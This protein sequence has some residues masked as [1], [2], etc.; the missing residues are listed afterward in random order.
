[1]PSLS[2]HENRFVSSIQC[3]AGRD[4][5]IQFELS[6]VSSSDISVLPLPFAPKDNNSDLDPSAI[7]GASQKAVEQIHRKYQTL[8]HLKAIW[9]S[10]SDPPHYDIYSR[11]VYITLEHIINGGD[12][13]PIDPKYIA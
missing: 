4:A 6:D 9:Y 7:L 2:K 12:F 1:M 10:P 8:F 5:Y 11:A 3:G 13:R